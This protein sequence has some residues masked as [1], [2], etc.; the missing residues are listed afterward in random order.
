MTDTIRSKAAPH[1]AGVAAKIWRECPACTNKDLERCLIGTAYDLGNEGKDDEYGWGLVQAE[2]SYHCLQTDVKC[3]G[4]VPKNQTNATE[5]TEESFRTPI[6]ISYTLDTEK[7]M[8]MVRLICIACSN[9]T[10][11]DTK[12]MQ[13][14]EAMV[15]F[16]RIRSFSWDELAV[17]MEDNVEFHSFFADQMDS[18]GK[19]SPFFETRT[20]ISS[21]AD[22]IRYIGQNTT[23]SGAEPFSVAYGESFMYYRRIYTGRLTLEGP[24]TSFECLTSLRFSERGKITKILLTLLKASPSN[25]QG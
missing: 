5:V 16:S 6:D 1:V 20:G 13:S 19:V 11:G 23:I 10:F 3:C 15:D 24:S 17:I 21:L 25:D 9:L 8:E 14:W 4:N 12:L 7:T 22:R 2:D 18:S